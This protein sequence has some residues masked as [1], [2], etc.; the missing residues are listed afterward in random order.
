RSRRAASAPPTAPAPMTAIRIRPFSRTACRPVAGRLADD[1]GRSSVR[2]TRNASA[3]N[4]SARVTGPTGI[5]LLDKP[6]GPTSH[7]LVARARRALG[8]RKVGH[9]GTLDPMATGLMILGVGS[10]T[11][12]LT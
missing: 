10:A 6:Q 4:A 2:P 8:T 1:V 5:L 7:D 9:A 3:R 11:R 12:L